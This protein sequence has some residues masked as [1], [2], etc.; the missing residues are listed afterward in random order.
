MSSAGGEGKEEIEARRAEDLEKGP[1]KH[2]N[3]YS[4][5]LERL[6]NDLEKTHD[7]MYV[8]CNEQMGAS[9]VFHILAR[10]HEVRVVAGSPAAPGC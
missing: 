4:E 8:F 5:N 6:L 9:S 1:W 2:M 7:I 3:A 10:R